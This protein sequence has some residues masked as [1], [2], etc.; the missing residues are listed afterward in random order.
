[1]KLTTH[2]QLVPRP[3]MVELYLHYPIRLRGVMLNLLS[4]GR[5]FTQLISAEHDLELLSGQINLVIFSLYYRSY[6]QM[7]YN[8]VCMY[9][10]KR[11]NRNFPEVWRLLYVATDCYF[12]VKHYLYTYICGKA[13]RKE[14]AR[15][16]KR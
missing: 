9:I 6:I 10:Y 4:T 3:R 2:L 11:V 16:T 15:K 7:F 14:T 8:Y 13:R 12:L 5:T 1:V